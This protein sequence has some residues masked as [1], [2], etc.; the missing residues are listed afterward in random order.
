MSTT[1]EERSA[2]PTIVSE[3]R[4]RASR[5]RLAIQAVILALII[6][7]ILGGRVVI[8]HRHQHRVTP[9]SLA[10]PAAAVP[11]SSEVELSWGLRI[12]NVIVVADNGG[13]ELRYQVLDDGKAAKIHQGTLTTNQ[14]PTLQVEGTGA[15]IT[16]SSVLMHFHHG[17]P[18]AGRSYSI[19]YGNAGGAV[20]SGDFITIIMKDGLKIKHV[21]VSD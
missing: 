8:Q 4:S 7:G 10:H 5:R 6:A 14:L 2:E 13:V 20:K 16:P 19:V 15:R 18:T 1:L 21:Q 17:D 12:T 11:I 3:G 9:V